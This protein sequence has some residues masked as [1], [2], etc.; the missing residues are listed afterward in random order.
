MSLVGSFTSGG[1]AVAVEDWRL[2]IKREG[3]HRKFVRRIPEVA[4]SGA[5]A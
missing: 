5:N 4:F 2:Q 3:Q 1:L